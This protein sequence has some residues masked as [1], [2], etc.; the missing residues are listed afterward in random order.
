MQY[1][2]AIKATTQYPRP[3]RSGYQIN[4]CSIF[5]QQ[6]NCAVF[7]ATM[8]SLVIRSTSAIYTHTQ[9][10][11][12]FGSYHALVIGSISAVYTIN[13]VIVQFWRLLCSGYQVN[14]CSLYQ[15]QSNCLTLAA[16]LWITGQS[17]QYI[18]PQ[19]Q[20]HSFDGCSALVIG[21]IIAVYTTTKAFV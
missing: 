16:M 3:L 1:I 9:A 14:Q 18:I 12:S 6:S 11:H 10:T 15:H 7:A 5:Y 19:K 8:L 4:Q 13:K 2:P 21:S 17:M 20:P